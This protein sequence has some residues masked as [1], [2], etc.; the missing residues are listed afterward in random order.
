LARYPLAESVASR[1]G[2]GALVTFGVVT[3]GVVTFGVADELFGNKVLDVCR[4]SMP[5]SLVDSSDLLLISAG[6]A[7]DCVLA[8]RLA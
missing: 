6:F 4:M 3:F 5:P 2:F 1:I 8:A 7:I